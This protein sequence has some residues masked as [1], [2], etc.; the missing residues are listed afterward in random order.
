MQILHKN[1]DWT[2][3]HLSKSHMLIALSLSL[4]GYYTSLSPLLVHM[5]VYTLIKNPGNYC[6]CLF[7]IPVEYS[8][9]YMFAFIIIW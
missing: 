5:S 4:E 8:L 2:K 9:K 1:S 3:S 7:L 6:Y